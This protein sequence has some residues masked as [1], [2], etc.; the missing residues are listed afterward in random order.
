MA[1]TSRLREDILFILTGDSY[2]TDRDANEKADGLK[3]QIKLLFLEVI[4]EHTVETA[5]EPGKEMYID[6]DGLIEAVKA[7]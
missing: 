1:S 4:K 5:D 2:S 6:E 3:E 7:L